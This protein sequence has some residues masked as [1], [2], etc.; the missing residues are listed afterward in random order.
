MMQDW[1]QTARAAPVWGTRKLIASSE[2]DTIDAPDSWDEL[3]ARIELTPKDAMIRGM[4]LREVARIAKRP[5]KPE[6]RYIPFS[7]YPVREYQ[8]LILRTAH[9]NHPDATPATAILR[10]GLHVYSLFASSLAGMAIFSV[11]NID[12][13]TV[14]D[15]AP[16][17]YSV[18]L[19]P[20]QMKA[21]HAGP[22]ET[23]IELRNVWPFPDIF[24]A[25]IWLGGMHATRVKGTLEIQRHSFCAADLRARWRRS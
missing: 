20:G 8:E 9:M 10:V 5:I 3:G 24:H 13:R 7:L 23:L 1:G 12:F 21:S 16:K 18:T 22:G 15:F 11:A 14:C 25:G 2:T 4:F 6:P 17:A 19:K